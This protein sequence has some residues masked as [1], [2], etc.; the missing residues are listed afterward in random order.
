MPTLV[1]AVHPRCPCSRATMEEL[2][3][4][5]AAHPHGLRVRVLFWKPAGAS[6]DWSRT[7][8]WEQAKRLPGATVSVDEG[9]VELKRFGAATSGHVLFYAGDGRLLFSGGV[10]VSRGHEGDSASLEALRRRI[11]GETDKYIETPVF[12]CPISD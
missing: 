11:R 3:R 4:T 10:T 1:V 7:G 12:G 5:L 8:L 2:A 6:D 9:G